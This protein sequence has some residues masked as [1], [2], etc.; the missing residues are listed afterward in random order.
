MLA[1]ARARL[2]L[3]SVRPLRCT[4]RPLASSLLS[5]HSA[6]LKTIQQPTPMQPATTRRAAGGM[7]ASALSGVGAAALVVLLGGGAW[8]LLNRP[9]DTGVG[10]AGGD[11]GAGGYVAPGERRQ[12]R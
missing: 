3:G 5:S 11:Y 2:R 8:M 12:Q 6:L 1:G 7:A 10:T 4:A 9:Q